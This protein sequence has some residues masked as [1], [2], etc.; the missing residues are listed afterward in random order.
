MACMDYM[1]CM[2]CK[3]D[4]DGKGGNTNHTGMV[5]NR[6]KN[7]SCRCMHL[8]CRMKLLSFFTSFC[9][10]DLL[11]IICDICHMIKGCIKVQSLSFPLWEQ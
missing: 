2:D 10:E 6:Q 7:A 4:K 1:D 8:V 9:D 11:N 5:S 3:V